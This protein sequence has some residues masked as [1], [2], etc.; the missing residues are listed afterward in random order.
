MLSVLLLADDIRQVLPSVLADTAPVRWLFS[1]L[2]T[3][4][5]SRALI[6]LALVIYL[7][8]FLLRKPRKKEKPL[9]ASEIEEMIEDW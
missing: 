9:S 3:W 2:T 6:D 5:L 1:N 7:V 4:E 8:F